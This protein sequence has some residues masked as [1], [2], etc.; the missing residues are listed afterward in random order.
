MRVVTFAIG[1]IHGS[2]VELEILLSRIGDWKAKHLTKMVPVKFKYVFIGDYIDRGPDSK[3]VID[4]ICKLSR[5]NNV[6][7]L[8]GNHE[9]MMLETLRPDCYPSHWLSNGGRQT[10]DSFQTEDI[11]GIDPKILRWI[12]ER[13]LYHDDGIR[14]YVHAGVDREPL[15][16]C[17]ANTI[18]W[19]RE[20]FL[21]NKRQWSRQIVH[22]HT[23]TNGH[24]EVK[25]NRI[26][27]D[28]GCCFGGRLTCV[29]FDNL[30]LK[31]LDYI[32]VEK[33]GFIVKVGPLESE[34]DR[35]APIFP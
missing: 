15:D 31:P 5:E 10:L 18:L 6:V 16:S 27:I 14:F 32:Q 19:I 28:T 34:A 17:S 4:R 33:Q 21:G 7:A 24:I 23:P 25:S 35:S 13:P 30:N 12:S 20:P 2:L 29:I 11:H 3:G 1:D 22:G 8:K 26:N 9:D